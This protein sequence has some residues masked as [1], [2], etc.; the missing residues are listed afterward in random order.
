MGILNDD[1]FAQNL[2]RFL[3]CDY[4]GGIVLFLSFYHFYDFSFFHPFYKCGIFVVLQLLDDD[5]LLV[6]PSG[7]HE[8]AYRL[9]MLHG[10]GGFIDDKRLLSLLER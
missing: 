3:V 4:L 2:R 9:D 6:V 7:G 10:D 5:D 8:F 1:E